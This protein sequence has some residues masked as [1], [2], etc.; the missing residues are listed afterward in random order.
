MAFPVPRNEEERKTKMKE[1]PT[2]R[3]LGKEGEKKQRI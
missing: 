2:N 1:T 3:S